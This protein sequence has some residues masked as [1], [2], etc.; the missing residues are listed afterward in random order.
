MQL[1]RL[2]RDLNTNRFYFDFF[3]LRVE[4]LV[5]HD[6]TLKKFLRSLAFSKFFT[7]VNPNSH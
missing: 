5:G 2:A 4:L 1:N 6:T 7:N 3:I